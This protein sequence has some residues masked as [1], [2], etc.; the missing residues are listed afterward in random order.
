MAE[1]DL[2]ESLIRFY[3]FQLGRLPNREEFKTALQSTFERQDLRLFFLLPFFGMAP[4]EKLEKKAEKQGISRDEVHAMVKRL[5]PEGMVDSYVEPS[6]R[7]V[8]RSPFIALIEF[9]VRLKESSP[10]RDVCVKVMNAFIDGATDAVPTRTPYYRVLPIEAALTGQ[11]TGGLSV[12]AIVPDPRE[13]LPIDIISQMIRK[14]TLIA[15]ADCY[16]RSTKRLINEDCGHP[17]ETCFY[18]NE[19]AKI[20]LETGYAREIDYEE[21]MQILWQCEKEGLVHNVSNCEGEIMTLCN[22]CT[23]SCAVMKAIDRGQTNV[24]GPSRYQSALIEEKC[25]YCGACLPV[26]P[27]GVISVA[28]QSIEF[29]VGK[30]IGCGHC[31]SACPEG[32]LTMVLRE[33]HPRIFPNN[34]ALFRRINFEAMLGLAARRILGR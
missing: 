31:V 9:Q 3:E 32:A 17:L 34:N 19:L 20:K 30:C 25:T 23:C 28:D 8:G 4:I 18:F 26:C 24:G 16:C 14:E 21:A 27:M 15:V 33:K 5:I 13:V 6:G 1:K 12:D 29:K 22:C 11:E 2:Y 7:L 10:M